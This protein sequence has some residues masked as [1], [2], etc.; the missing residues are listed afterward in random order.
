[1]RNL[2]ALFILVFLLVLDVAVANPSSQQEW[3]FKVLLDGKP[4]GEQN[5]VVTNED[6]QTRLETAADFRVK[7]LFAT[8]YR[9]EHQN[10]ETWDGNCLTGIESTTDANGQPFSVTG[11][12]RDGFFEVI[13]EDRRDE[14][15][16]C[17]MSFAYWNPDFLQHDRLLNSQNGE[18][19]EVEVSAAQPD[20][21]M[22]RGERVPALR[23]Q[24][25]AGDLD[26]R[27]WYSTDNKWLALESI[28]EGDR[29]LSYE[30]L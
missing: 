7:F 15:P 23:Y 16:D 9:Y 14:L 3:S 29:V 18:Y 11:Q 8:V 5:F 2:T 30:L 22:V 6:G 25:K 20:T 4:V 19:M 21:R 28:T 12:K 24:L 27:L 13:G 10:V 26:L 1:M 17:V